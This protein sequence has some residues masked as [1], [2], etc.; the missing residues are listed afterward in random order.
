MIQKYLDGKGWQ[1][2]L[3]LCGVP[4]D[5]IS[6]VASNAHG[7][8][9]GVSEYRADKTAEGAGKGAGGD[10][11]VVGARPERDGDDH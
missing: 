5:A 8:H 4:H 10:V 9:A 2:K 3:E 11:D 6:I 7:E 1:A